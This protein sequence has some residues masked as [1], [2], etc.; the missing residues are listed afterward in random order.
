MNVCN[1]DRFGG[2]VNVYLDHLKF[3]AVYYWSVVVNVMMSLI[4]VMDPP[5]LVQPI[6]TYGDE[7][8]YFGCFCFRGELGFLNCDD[9]YM[10]IVNKQFELLAYMLTCSCSI[11][12]FISLLL[13][14]LCAC[15]VSV[16][17][18]LPLVCL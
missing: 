4:C 14:G 9:I 5:C 3:C 1:C 6:Y 2:V 11:M 13:L 12:I 8:M 16:V 15:A 10:C 7:V 17:I 18:W